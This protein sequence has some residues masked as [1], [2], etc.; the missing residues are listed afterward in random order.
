M[1]VHMLTYLIHTLRQ[2]VTNTVTETLTI[3][4]PTGTL[5]LVCLSPAKRSKD[6]TRAGPPQTH[7]RH[8]QTDT[9]D[10]MPTAQWAS[11]TLTPVPTSGE[12]EMHTPHLVGGPLKP[13][14]NASLP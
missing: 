12:V 3:S 2:M 10:R 5:M 13:G 1:L 9:L 4:L 7:I 6:H 14:K 8:A 11:D